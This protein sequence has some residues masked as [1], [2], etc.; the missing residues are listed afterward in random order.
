MGYD[1]V[2]C[3]ID[4]HTRLAYAEIH[5]DENA[6]TCAA[7]LHAAAAWF[8]RTAISDYHYDYRTGLET[9]PGAGP[10]WARMYELGTGRPLF[11]RSLG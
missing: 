3:A 2:H 9:R 6:A 11:S 5:P 8:R 10:L 1:Y 4:D 7:F